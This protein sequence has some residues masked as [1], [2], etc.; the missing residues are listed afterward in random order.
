MTG[1]TTSAFAPASVGNV[2][3]G[4]DTL[5]HA[6]DVAG[7]TVTLRSADVP[8]VRLGR[9][10]GVLDAL[11]A[12]P[13]RNTA[14]RPLLAMMS[15]HAVESGVI[16]D[17]DKGIALGSGMGG[18]AASAVACVVAANAHWG[19]ALE[20]ERL[21]AYAMLGE[22]VASDS[23][24]AD[25][26]APS[27][28][29]GLVLCEGSAR[30]RVTTL[31]VPG[32]LRCVLVHPRISIETRTGRGVLGAT[33]RLTD[34]VRQSQ[35]LAGFVAG[36][37]RSDPDQIARCLRDVVIEP[38]R[39]RLIPGFGPAQRAALD[40]GALGCSISGSGPSVFAWCRADDAPAVRQALIEAFGT[41]GLAATGWI[42]R[43]DAPGARLLAIP[44]ADPVPLP[45]GRDSG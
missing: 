27:L 15:D 24:H 37:L 12:D 38:Q 20:P 2:G 22:T 7:D 36:C 11:P 5:G 31:P 30:P 14:L 33:V 43:I 35:Y 41:A 32:D 40:A 19:L 34:F 44:G 16:V 21:L 29:G 13:Q 25:N 8:G 23:A 9:V 6:L 1:E 10:T 42:S 26:A 4:F 3:V 39:S 45:A 17:V 28:Y 18:S